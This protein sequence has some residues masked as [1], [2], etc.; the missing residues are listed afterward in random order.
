MLQSWIVE[1]PV[2]GIVAEFAAS[3][4]QL[5]DEL[6]WKLNSELFDKIVMTPINAVDYSI[7]FED[8]SKLLAEMD[9]QRYGVICSDDP[10]LNNR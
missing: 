1:S 6:A 9:R 2:H 10:C 4:K 3:R 8:E 5:A 7:S